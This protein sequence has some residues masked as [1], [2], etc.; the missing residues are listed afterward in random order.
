MLIRTHCYCL[1]SFFLC[2][3]SHSYTNRHVASPLL[4][5]G[6]QQQVRYI[7]A[8]LHDLLYIVFLIF[9]VGFEVTSLYC[10]HFGVPKLS[11]PPCWAIS[12]VLNMSMQEAI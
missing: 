1:L 8:L 12:D 4:N 11:T 5:G 6:G 2:D 7:A 3:L 9:R 10:V